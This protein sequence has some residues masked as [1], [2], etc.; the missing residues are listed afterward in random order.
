MVLDT[1]TILRSSASYH[2]H[3]MLLYIVS[4]IAVSLSVNQ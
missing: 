1:G 2:D 3:R 4:W